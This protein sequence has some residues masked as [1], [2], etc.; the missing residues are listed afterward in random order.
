MDSDSQPMDTD[1]TFQPFT[2]AERIQQLNEID[3]NISQIMVHTD[4]ALTALTPSTQ[5]PLSVQQ[6]TFKSSMDAFITTLHTIDVRMKRQIFGL[7]EAGIINLSNDR[8]DASDQ[9]QKASLNP[10]A[11]GTVGNLDVGWLNS[12]KNRVE[13]EMEAELWRKGREFLEAGGKGEGEGSV[14]K[15]EPMEE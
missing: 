5:T 6:Q 1:D 2:L 7:E 15:G 14:V 3:K 11:V 10:T 12:R 13:R 8:S 9:R 4:T